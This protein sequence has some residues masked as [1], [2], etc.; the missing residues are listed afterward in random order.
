M[1]FNSALLLTI[2][3]KTGADRKPVELGNEYSPVKDIF[4]GNL[5]VDTEKMGFLIKLI[6]SDFAGEM[7]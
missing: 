2:P 5:K 3:G 6:S 1:S 4:N 7:K